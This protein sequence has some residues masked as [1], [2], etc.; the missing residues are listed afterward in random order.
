[1]AKTIKQTNFFYYHDIIPKQSFNTKSFRTLY[2]TDVFFFSY[3]QAPIQI[4]WKGWKDQFSKVARYALEVFKLVKGR[5]GTLKEPYTDLVPNPVPIT[6][7]EFNETTEGGTHSF[8][9]QPNNP[10]VYSCILEINDRANNSAYVRRFVIYDPISS[11]T[12]DESHP[13][14]ATSGNPAANYEWQNINPNTFTFT[15]KNHFLNKLH[16]DGNFL[17]R[18]SLFP[19]SLDDGGDRN[20]YKTIQYDDTEGTRSRYAIPNERGIIKYD[21]AYNI[22]K[23]QSSPQVYQHQN[24]RN[25]SIEIFEHQNLRDGNSYTIWVKAYDILGNTKEERFVLH[26]DSSKPYVSSEE[27]QKN[28]EEDKM[29]FTS[30]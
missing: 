5:D 20:A 23:D 27:L 4:S 10:G 7:R 17:A 8:T 21:V 12:S 14:Y 15:W 30:R 3:T 11:V 16:G 2:L 22:G 28:V 19:D 13:F 1:M 26:Y 24:Y 9:Y 29:N 25:N 18:I 6:I